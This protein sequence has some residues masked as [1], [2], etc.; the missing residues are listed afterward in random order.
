M[1]SRRRFKWPTWTGSRQREVPTW[2]RD[3]EVMISVAMTLMRAQ[4][5]E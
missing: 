2:P 1:R 3:T 5:D 4:G